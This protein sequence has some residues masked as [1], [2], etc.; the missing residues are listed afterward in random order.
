MKFVNVKKFAAS[1]TRYITEYLERYPHLGQGKRRAKA[2]EVDC[3]LILLIAG[4]VGGL[5]IRR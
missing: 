4:G 1:T 5:K 2:V 3:S